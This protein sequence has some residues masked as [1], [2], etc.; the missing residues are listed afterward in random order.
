MTLPSGSPQAGLAACPPFYPQVTHGWDPATLCPAFPGLGCGPCGL[1]P[2]CLFPHSQVKAL[3]PQ[4]CMGCGDVNGMCWQQLPP[5]PFPGLF[6]HNLLPVQPMGSDGQLW[7]LGPCLASACLDS[8]YAALGGIRLFLTS[9]L[10]ASPELLTS[11]DSVCLMPHRALLRKLGVLFLP[12]ETN[13]S[14]DSSEGVLARAVVQAVSAPSGFVWGLS[15]GIS[16]YCCSG[17]DTCLCYHLPIP[18]RL[19]SSC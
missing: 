6:A 16:A 14:L 10:V 3:C 15:Q 13:L 4:T 12:P 17:L 9:C 18:S 1:G 19:W 2:T 8:T 11:S 7:F 5:G